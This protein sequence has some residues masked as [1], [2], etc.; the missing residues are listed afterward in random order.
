MPAATRVVLLGVVTQREAWGQTGR[1]CRW[2]A[3]SRRPPAAPGGA[4]PVLAVLAG[5]TLGP[6]PTYVGSPAPLLWRRVLH[7]HGD[8][9][10]RGRFTRLGLPTVPV[11]LVASTPALWVSLRLFGT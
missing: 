8:E 3:S 9:A 5:V 10:E 6:D 2:S 4:G 1:C 11:T 7:R